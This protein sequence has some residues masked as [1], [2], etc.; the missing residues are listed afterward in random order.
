[1]L[2]W[3]FKRISSHEEMPTINILYSWTK[4]YPILKKAVNSSKENRTLFKLE[5]E[6][7]GLLQSLE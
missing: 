5:N 3:T 1:M 6:L 2:G 7:M 4:R